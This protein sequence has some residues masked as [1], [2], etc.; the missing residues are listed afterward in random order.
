MYFELCCSS[1]HSVK[2]CCLHKSHL[3]KS[4]AKMIL[5]YSKLC[6]FDISCYSCKN[7]YVYREENCFAS[8]CFITIFFTCM[9]NAFIFSFIWAYA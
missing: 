3:Y 9:L 5:L 8:Y 4:I 1:I 7:I 2:A 6:I